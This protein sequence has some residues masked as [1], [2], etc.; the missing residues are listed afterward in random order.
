M[1]GE[2][3]LEN[4]STDVRLWDVDPLRCAAAVGQG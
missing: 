2:V 3:G 4:L 1:A